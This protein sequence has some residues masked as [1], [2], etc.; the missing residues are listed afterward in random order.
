MSVC[1][2]VF[3]FCGEKEE[4]E[5]GEKKGRGRVVVGRDGQSVVWFEDFLNSCERNE[6]LGSPAAAAPSLPP[7]FSFA[8]SGATRPCSSHKQSN[9]LTE[10]AGKGSPGHL[11]DLGCAADNGD[12]FDDGRVQRRAELRAQGDADLSSVRGRDRGDVPGDLLDLDDSVE[13]E[14]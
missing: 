7:S 2:E 10:S 9:F 14:D 11:L 5:E 1:F 4:V 6:D 13:G 8:E 12:E 3:E